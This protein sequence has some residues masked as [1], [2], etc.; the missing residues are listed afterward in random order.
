MLQLYS[1][2]QQSLENLEKPKAAVD[3][4]ETRTRILIFYYPRNITLLWIPAIIRKPREAKNRA[5]NTRETRILIFYYPRYIATLLWI[6]A[7]VR[8]PR[9]AK[10]RAINT[11]ETRRRISE[12]RKRT[13]RQRK[14][15]FG[16]LH[17]NKGSKLSHIT[18][19][20]VFR[21]FRPG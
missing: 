20:R 6:P 17:E 7:I 2:F 4:R 10:N 3:T 9:E 15:R 18:W 16:K 11:R 19:K 1:E 12:E 5:V 14:G 13:L 8:K 21:D